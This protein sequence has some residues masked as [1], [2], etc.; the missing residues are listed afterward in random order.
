MAFQPAPLEIFPSILEN[1]PETVVKFIKKTHHV[2]SHVQIDIADGLLV[3][4][5]TYSVN[6]W[7]TY[8][9]EHQSAI[10][11]STSSE[12][13]LMVQNF[14][15]DVQALATISSCMKIPTVLLHFEA[16]KSWYGTECVDFYAALQSD[17][18]EFEYGIV[19]EEKTPVQDN[20][21]LISAFPIVQIMTI[22]AGSQGRPFNVKAL[23]HIKTLREASYYGKIQ[24][25]GGINATTLPRILSK[26][27]APNAVCPGSYLKEDT[28]KHLEE[29]QKISEAETQISD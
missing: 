5:Q 29:L 25:D 21:P 15:P 4:G 14:I 7:V 6:D 9:L 23:Q 8:I 20:L 1:D 19:I 11:E 10:P 13:H 17:C 26:K 3:D 28:E 22:E 2:F 16:L 24:L 18:S 27:Y 12:F